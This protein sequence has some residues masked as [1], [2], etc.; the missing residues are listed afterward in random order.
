MQEI[1]DLF[2]SIIRRRYESML[3]DK[4]KL[5]VVEFLFFVQNDIRLNQLASDTQLEELWEHVRD[6][7][8]LTDFL[9][10]VSQD[11]AFHTDSVLWTKTQEQLARAYTIVY[12]ASIELE[13]PLGDETLERM[14]SRGTIFKFLEAYPWLVAI[15]MIDLTD[16]QKALG[17][18]A[19]ELKQLADGEAAE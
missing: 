18:S 7:E 3:D 13:T 14:A 19:E 17:V 8:T 1:L 6:Q 16:L 2:A 9:F 11:L 12:E 15:F 5:Q 4:Q 10:L